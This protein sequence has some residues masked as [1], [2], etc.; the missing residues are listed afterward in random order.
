MT[1]SLDDADDMV[2]E[3]LLRAWRGLPGFEGQSSSG[4][5][6]TASRLTCA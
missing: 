3:V 1:A 2:Q 6:Y 4:A 5:S